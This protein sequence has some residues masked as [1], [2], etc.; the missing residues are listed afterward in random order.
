LVEK[1]LRLGARFDR[2]GVMIFSVSVDCSDG[3]VWDVVTMKLL[4][5]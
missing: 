4:V 1:A 2:I 3:F 5:V